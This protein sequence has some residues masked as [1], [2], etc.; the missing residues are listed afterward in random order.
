MTAGRESGVGARLRPTTPG[1]KSL[2]SL[3]SLCAAVFLLVL[4]TSAIAMRPADA[5]GRTLT[6]E[7][8]VVHLINA[9]R[10]QHGAEPLEY[11]AKLTR[12]AR[13]HTSDLV[14]RGLLDHDSGDGTPFDQRVR[15]FVPARMVGET[16]AAV[17]GATDAADMVVRLWMA[18]PPHRAVMLTGAFRRMGVAREAGPFG[19]APALVITADF[20]SG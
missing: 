2:R 19:S 5:Q 14:R 8:R 15:G 3:L 4:F 1:R 9:V 13:V 6:F 20:A 12:A 18:S 16:L 11:C 17:R 10:L 7:R